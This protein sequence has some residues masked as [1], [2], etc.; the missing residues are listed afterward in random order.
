MLDITESLLQ[1]I[2]SGSKLKTHMAYHSKTDSRT[3]T[4]YLPFLTELG[5]IKLAKSDKYEITR[6]GRGF[7]KQYSKLRKYGVVDEPT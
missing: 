7:L 6:K 3:I 2:V 5:L 4:R 1:A